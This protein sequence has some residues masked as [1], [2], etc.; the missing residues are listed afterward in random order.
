MSL[1]LLG[2]LMI[3]IVN[4]NIF[5]EKHKK[6]RDT[7]YK[8][9]KKERIKMRNDILNGQ[10]DKYLDERSKVNLNKK[11]NEEKINKLREEQDDKN[12]DKSIN[13]EDN[14]EI[15]INVNKIEESENEKND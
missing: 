11:L 14:N 12:S 13:I 10:Y 3:C 6:R 9:R 1:G 4:I 7:V 15:L 8:L 2:I 5:S